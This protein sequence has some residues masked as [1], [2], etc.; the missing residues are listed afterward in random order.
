M[1]LTGATGY[2]GG[3]LL[4]KLQA[5]GA[6]VRC[7]VRNP[8]P[9]DLQ[10]PASVEVVT[11]D[12]LDEPCVTAA[13]SGVDVA[14]YLI[15]SMRDRGDFVARDR[16]AASVFARAGREAGVRRIIY[17]SGLGDPHHELSRH[18]RSRHEV[19]RI[20]ASSGV[21]VIELRASI[22][23]GAG[24]ESFEV[25]RALVDRL[26][27]MVTPRWVSQLCQPLAIDDALRYLLGAMALQVQES[28]VIQI[29]G[30]DRVAYG[31]LMREYAR[32]RG[33]RRVIVPVPVLTP[34]LSSLWLALITPVHFRV[35]RRLIEGLSAP[36]IVRDDKAARLFDFR[37][38]G[39]REAIRCA[40]SA[41]EEDE[42]HE[43]R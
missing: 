30:P 32:Q 13:M 19:G 22:I 42:V 2:V 12:A 10:A 38:M 27:A 7:L 25:L 31:D 35:G 23:I 43:K 6:R 8:R 5:S 28:R 4:D 39:V 29:G 33:F 34:W 1:L 11:G 41:C 9:P 26:P 18:L 40:I 15:H 16:Q 36:T 21:Q 20:L 37:P 3:R 17:L 14:Y 24:S